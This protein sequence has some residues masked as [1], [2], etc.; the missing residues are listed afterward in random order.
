[1]RIFSDSELAELNKLYPEAVGCPTCRGRKLY[2]WNSETV[3]CDCAEQIKLHKLYN[4]AGIGKLYQ[5]LTWNDIP[6]GI[7][8]D[9]ERYR[10]NRDALID[11]G[12]G[13]VI[14]GPHGTGKTLVATILL[15]ELVREGY[16]C[17][18]TT[19]A[20][21]IEMYTDSWGDADKK[22]QFF[23]RFMLSR[24]V[25]LDDLGKEFRGKLSPTTFDYI[26]RT[27]VQECRPTI[28]TSNL[29]PLQIENEYGIAALSLLVEQSIE[30]NLLGHDYRVSANRRTLAEVENGETRSIQ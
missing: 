13:L 18:A 4:F 14:H 7:P 11:R 12:V 24:V 5:R 23:S 25:L 22:R 1:M 8:S 19:F 2:T 27:R 28:V 15:K 26:L 29:S 16:D 21:C 17:F 30:V 3:S 6:H 20:R 10:R 9:I